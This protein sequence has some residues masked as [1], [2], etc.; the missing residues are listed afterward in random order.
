MAINGFNLPLAFTGQEYIRTQLYKSFGVTDEGLSTYFFGP[1][2]LAWQRMSNIQ[3]RG[4]PLPESWMEQQFNLQKQILQRYFEL[5]I[6][7]VPPAFNGAVSH[8]M[9]SIFPNSTIIRLGTW[10]DFPSGYCCPYIV[11]SD[12]ALFTQ[13]GSAFIQLQKKLYGEGVEDLHIYNCDIFN[14]NVPQSSDPAYL[15]A[16]SAAVYSSMKQGDEQAMWLMQGWLFVD[17]QAFW[18]PSAI[19]A[20][21]S[22]VPDNGM[23]A[24]PRFNFRCVADVADF[25]C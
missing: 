21:L 8:E 16:V 4:G 1:A 12:D 13:L 3:A 5:G 6:K 19:T 11:A 17:N 23:Y 24:N 22:G 18:T 7:P 20:F 14:E 2:F 9:V 10:C 15:N 25:S